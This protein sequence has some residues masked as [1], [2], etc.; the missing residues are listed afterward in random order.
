MLS[1]G[2]LPAPACLS[3]QRRALWD[4]IVEEYTI[5]SAA[6]PMLETYLY[7][8]DCVDEAR[9]KIRVEGAVMKDRFGV[10]KP[11][12]WTARER[13]SALVA[14]RAFRLLGFDQKPPSQG[15]LFT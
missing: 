7:A 8:L 4:R 9:E 15:S 10:N 13:D 5:D 6:A 3:E 2:A 11:N 14:Q 12:P 1:D